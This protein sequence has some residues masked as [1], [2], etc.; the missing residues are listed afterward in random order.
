MTATGFQQ[1]TELID[2]WNRVLVPKFVR[3]R[4]ILV[5]GTSNHSA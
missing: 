2:F 4:H 1:S 5:E 3:F